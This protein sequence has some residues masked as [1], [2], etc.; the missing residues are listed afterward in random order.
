MSFYQSFTSLRTTE[1]DPASLLKNIQAID[2]TAGIQH[3]PGTQTYIIKTTTT[4]SPTN[5]TNCQNAIDTSPAS[6]PELAAQSEV[7]K[8][9]IFQKAILLTLLDQIN[10][11]RTKL[12]MTTITVSQAIQ[13]VRDKAGTL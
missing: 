5:I 6:T 8:M 1:P 4:L 7:D 10:V 13:A 2:S 9:T 12:S 11:L 3:S